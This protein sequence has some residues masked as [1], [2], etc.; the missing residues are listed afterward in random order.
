MAPNYIKRP[1]WGH[2]LW[3]NAIA[4]YH[5]VVFSGQGH[6]LSITD[7][8]ALWE[9]YGPFDV[10]TVGENPRHIAKYSNV[11][12]LPFLKVCFTSDYFND[13]V[14]QYNKW[15]NFNKI[16]VVFLASRNCQHRMNNLQ[17]ARVLSMD[18]ET[19]WLPWHVDTEIFKPLEMEKVYDV[20]CV[21]GLYDP[22]Y[23]K[24]RELMSIVDRMPYNT[25]TGSWTHGNFKQMRY[26]KVINESKIF[27]CVNGIF[28]EVTMKYTECMACGTLFMTDKPNDADHLG[29]RHGENIVFYRDF[30][31][32][33][34][35]VAYYLAHDAKREEIAWNGL[36]HVVENYSMEQ[37]VEKFTNIVKKK[38]R[39]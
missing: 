15:I 4:K 14:H 32:M 5:D 12:R 30:K 31:D 23:P 18:A 10:V 13:N 37:G 38:L 9:K 2:Q 8:L 39:K 36:R 7:A 35:K 29:F 20:M 19:H 21:A 28:N 6:P 33:N 26:V 11:G 34:E 17:M 1:N 25:V 16:D 24:R 3:K 27:V 22:T